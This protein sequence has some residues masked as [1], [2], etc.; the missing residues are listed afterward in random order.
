MSEQLKRSLLCMAT[1]LA[2]AR[3]RLVCQECENTPFVLSDEGKFIECP[4]CGGRYMNTDVVREIDVAMNECL[5]IWGD[6]PHGVSGRKADAL[7]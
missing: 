4:E 5:K 1:A 6:L 2:K 7:A 3:S